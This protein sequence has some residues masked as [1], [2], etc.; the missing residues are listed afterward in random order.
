MVPVQVRVT[1]QLLERLDDL[2]A[3]GIYS[4]RSEAIRDAI[5]THVTNFTVQ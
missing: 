3:K 1:R 2:V 4:N 5:R